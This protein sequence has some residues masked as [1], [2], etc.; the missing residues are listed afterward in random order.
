MAPPVALLLWDI[1]HTLVDTGGFGRR[2]YETAIHQVTGQRLR[3]LADMTGRTDWAILAD[4]L[5]LHGVAATDGPLR[6]GYE[7]LA[8]A[9]EAA[10]HHVGGQAL[11]GALAAL[12][13]FAAEPVVQS[14]V[15]GN[16]RPIAFVKLDA[17]QLTPYLDLDIGGYGSDGRERA[18]IVRAAWQRANRKLGSDLPRDRVFVIGD[19]PHDLKAAHAAGVQAIGVASGGSS[20]EELQAEQPVAVLPDLKDFAN[21]RALI[22]GA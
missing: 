8:A 17:F 11:P 15:T 21:L 1:D 14:V 7:A 20:L 2:L 3:E 18:P 10:R 6:A 19:T 5:E 22:L 4:T 16:I 9:A 12:G 13:G